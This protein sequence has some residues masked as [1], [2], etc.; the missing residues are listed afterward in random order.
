M[1]ETTPWG[2]IGY[3]TFKRTYARR[4]DDS[5]PNSD[6]EELHDVVNRELDASDKQLKVG[7]TNE[8]KLL[9]YNT[10]MNLKWSVAGRFMWQLGTNTVDK[11]GLPSLQNCAGVVVDSPIRPFT[12][13]FE[14]LMLGSGVGY[15]IQREYVYQLPKLKDKIEI[16]RVDAADADF[17]VPDTR[18]GWVKLLGK[19]LKAHFY[20]GKGFTYSV[21][22]VRSKGAVIKGFGGLASGPEELCW[23][24]NEISNIL[25]SRANRKLRPI[26][27]LDIMNIIGFVVVSGNVRRSAQIAIGDYD[28]MQFLKAKRWD[29]GPIP[30]WRSMSNNSVACDDIE[31]LPQEFWDTY[32]QGEPYGLINLELSRKIGRTGETEYSDEGVVVYNPCAEQSLNNY[33]TCCLGMIYLP[34]IS[35][36]DELIQCLQL[37]YRMCKHSLALHCSLPETEDIVHSLMRMGIGM[38]GYL[39]ATEEQKGWLNDAYKWL[40]QYDIDYSK[41]HGFPVSIK[42]TTSKPDGTNALLPGVTPGCLVNPA[43]PYYIRRIRMA[44]NSNLLDVCKAHGYHVEPQINFD[45]S[46]DNT[47]MVVEFPCKVPETTPIAGNFSWKEQIDVIRRVQRE[48]S[49]NAVSCTVTYNLEDLE[50]IKEYLKTYY[51]DEIKTISFL[52]YQ[53]HGFK[54]AP[55]ETISK[56][57]YEELIKNTKPIT[58]ITVKETDFD[59]LECENGACPIK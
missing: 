5:N 13:T 54:Q 22:L 16:K 47:T 31:R 17:I 53:N 4:L 38:P 25:N 45:G 7:F 52:L 33:E 14:M 39:Q 15:N 11:L 48:W 51:K 56:E 30:N 9:Y 37:C 55:Y 44:T 6:T 3:V 57:R 19:V 12:W 59:V 28:D 18:E 36:Y 23:G 40:R 43:G 27:C 41:Q 35:S 1:I 10:R 24:M 49:D 8:E 20:T 32:K 26:D 42:L 58:S 34:M 46:I 2:E 29:L 21:Q 50:D